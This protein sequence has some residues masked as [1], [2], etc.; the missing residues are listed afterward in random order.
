MMKENIV[1]E[2]KSWNKVTVSI[3]QGLFL[4]KVNHNKTKAADRKQLQ[5]RNSK[6]CTSKDNK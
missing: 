1:F 4:S 6:G 3:L 2:N 5:G